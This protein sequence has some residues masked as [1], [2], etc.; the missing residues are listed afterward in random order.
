MKSFPR[1]LTTRRLIILGL[2][3][4]V[5]LL[6][7]VGCLQWR[8]ARDFRA[9]SEGVARSRDLQQSLE[10]FLSNLKD[11]ESSQRG[12]LLTHRESYLKPYY[13]A[14]ATL[15]MQLQAIG[16][17]VA[18]NSDQKSYYSQLESR[19]DSKLN[20]LAMTVYLEKNKNHRVAVEIVQTDY[21]KNTMDDIRSIISAMQAVE[22]NRLQQREDNY[23][24][25]SRI[26]FVLSA[27]LIALGLGF[28]AATGLLLRRM[29]R[30]QSMITICAWS[31]LIEYEGEWLTVEEYLSRRLSARVT[32]GISRAEAEK[33][34]KLLEEEKRGKVA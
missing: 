11:A 14:D 12:Y 25:N 5:L 32:H 24:R 2:S 10:A 27:L 3:V 9:S 20:E 1:I 30:M 19:M 26:N 21:G 16:K 18:D 22:T 4:P 28:I 7:L 31:K 15:R 23:Q 17:L 6:L 34:L 8:T 13:D 33:M 29:E